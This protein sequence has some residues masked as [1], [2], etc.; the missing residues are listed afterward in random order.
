MDQLI[1]VL[2]E[3]IARNWEKPL[4]NKWLLNLLIIAE[5]NKQLHEEYMVKDNLDFDEH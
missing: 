5:M 3:S 2:E 4:T 1:L